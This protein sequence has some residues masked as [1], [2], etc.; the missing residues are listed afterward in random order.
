MIEDRYETESE[1]VGEEAVKHIN[2]RHGGDQRN[3][4]KVKTNQQN[5]KNERAVDK[6]TCENRYNTMAK[7]SFNKDTVRNHKTNDMSV[8]RAVASSKGVIQSFE[9][10]NIAMKNQVQKKSGEM[11]GKE[12]D[13][14][15]KYK[16][17]M[18]KELEIMR[19]EFTIGDVEFDQNFLRKHP[20]AR[21]KLIKVMERHKLAF[22][23][24]VGCAPKRY[25][26]FAK[27]YDES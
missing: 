27:I 15:S 8:K 4:Y 19:N 24:T 25:E 14:R 3:R 6:D 22:Q 18:D 12:I 5:G 1:R 2:E 20:E 16:R 10:S 13:A 9:G 26:I 23:N 21:G 7:D 17:R 11:I